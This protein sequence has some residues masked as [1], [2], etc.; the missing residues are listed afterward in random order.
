VESV[1]IRQLTIEQDGREG[2][3]GQRSFGLFA[4][5]GSI[6]HHIV[7]DERGSQ[8]V[9]HFGMILDKQNAHEMPRSD[10]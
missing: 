5:G 3:R 1:S 4:R 7:A 8:C 6:N 9:R 2:R 10:L